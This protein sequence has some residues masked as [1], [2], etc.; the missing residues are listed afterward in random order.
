MA[1]K[2]KKFLVRGRV[3]GVGFRFFAVRTARAEGVSGSVRNLGNGDVEVVAQAEDSVLNTLETQL[4]Q[5]PPAAEVSDVESTE[6]PLDKS[7]SGFR[8]DY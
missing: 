7:V 8:I 2:R 1:E 5:G 3:Q 4:R 6:V